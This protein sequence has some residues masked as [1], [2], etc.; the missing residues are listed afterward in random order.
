MKDF[1]MLFHSEP[2]PNFEPTPAEIQAEIKEL[3]RHV[4]TL[5]AMSW[6]L[7]IFLGI[8]IYIIAEYCCQ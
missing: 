7:A 8:V 2:D 5:F 6:T 3:K 4:N 1:M